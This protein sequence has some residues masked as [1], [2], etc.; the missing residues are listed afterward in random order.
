MPFPVSKQFALTVATTRNKVAMAFN[1]TQL[2]YFSKRALQSGDDIRVKC[3]SVPVNDW[4]SSN[5]FEDGIRIDQ[6]NSAIRG[7]IEGIT[8]SNQKGNTLRLDMI[9]ISLPDQVLI[10]DLAGKNEIQHMMDYE[11]YT[12]LENFVRT[13]FLL[14]RIP[15]AKKRNFSKDQSLVNY[16]LSCNFNQTLWSFPGIEDEERSSLLQTFSEFDIMEM[17]FFHRIESKITNDTV[18]TNIDL[19]TMLADVYGMTMVQAFHNNPKLLQNI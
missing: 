9:Q 17:L 4:F 14:Y 19:R 2:I 18:D 6:V 8:K 10:W 7:Q 1:S 11:K 3:D 12:K 13:T 16:R 5:Y 15:E